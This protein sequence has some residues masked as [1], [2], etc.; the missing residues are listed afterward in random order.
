M[1]AHRTTAPRWSGLLRSVVTIVLGLSGR[2]DIAPVRVPRRDRPA[3]SYEAPMPAANPLQFGRAYQLPPFG[4]GNGLDA[5]FWT[6][7]ERLPAE[8]VDA[9]LAALR[10]RDI[11][12]WVAPARIPGVDHRSADAPHDLWAA[13]DRSD[14]ALDVVV[15]LGRPG[16]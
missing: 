13:A 4:R 12:A 11:P 8:R 3:A 1:G 5:L 16:R 7:S 14:E 15:R 2:R 9:V 6:P 10:E